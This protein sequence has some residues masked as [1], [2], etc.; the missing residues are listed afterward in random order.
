MNN[1]DL[2]PLG[3]PSSLGGPVHAGWTA[4]DQ[5]E[6]LSGLNQALRARLEPASL[7]PARLARSSRKLEGEYQF[8][9][10]RYLRAKV[11]VI[12]LEQLWLNWA[13]GAEQETLTNEEYQA[14]KYLKEGLSSTQISDYISLLSEDSVTRPL[15]GL[16]SEPKV[17]WPIKVRAFIAQRWTD[18]L[19]QHGLAVIR[20]LGLDILPSESD[21]ALKE[22][23]YER[24]KGVSE[25]IRNEKEMLAQFEDQTITD[26]ITSREL[27][28]LENMLK[29]L[30]ILDTLGRRLKMGEQA[31]MDQVN[32]RYLSLKCKTLVFKVKCLELEILTSTY[33][34]GSLPALKKIR[35]H[36]SESISQTN[37]E[38]QRVTSSLAQYTSAGSEFEEVVIEYVKVLEEIQGKK[39]ALAELKNSS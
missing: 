1:T 33:K 37:A 21:L 13:M 36:L 6:G 39:W 22:L 16:D 18:C 29:N 3:R 35:N 17:N 8:Q 2:D 23:R 20:P 28:L 38:I 24:M 25:H 30:G 27:K 5:S 11:G 4:L 9:R 32:I 15:M 19:F 31:Y 10:M 26:D 14:L 7:L 34:S 12:G